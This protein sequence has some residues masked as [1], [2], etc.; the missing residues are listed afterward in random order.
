MRMVMMSKRKLILEDG[1]TFIGK[2]FGSDQVTEG[3]VIFN[4]GMTGY[5]EMMSDP[6][7]CG[8]IAVMTY[9]SIGSYGINRDDFESITPFINGLVTKEVNHEPSNFRSEE[10][11]DAFMK[12]YNIPGISGIDTRMLTRILRDKGTMRGM[13]TDADT[14]FESVET[15]LKN[16]EEALL[17]EK[18]SITRPYI[19]PGDGA[20]VVV[21]DLGMKQ[22]IL[23]ELTNL[24]C[25]VTVVPYDYDVDEILRFKPDGILVANGPGNP[26]Y[27]HKTVQTVQALL[28]KTPIFGIGLGHQILAQACGAKIA[29][30]KAGN[31]GPGFPVKDLATD[32]TWLTTQSRHYYVDEAS[33]EGTNLHVTF[34]SLN[35]KTIEGLA[36]DTYPAFSVQFNPEGAPGANDTVYLFNQFIDLMT[37]N[38]E[39]NGGQR[40]A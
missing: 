19:V 33:L 8:H 12:R 15:V 28:G 35:D 30:L 17:V 2:A 29:K 14:T 11:L 34:R 4:T 39:K 27:V 7:Y 9:P 20:R 5:Q 38:T 23:H 37:E 21:V 22:T 10:T 13:I 6:N 31:Y 18:T 1:T 36:H 3:E 26:T 24:N 40:H 32:Q 25:H 16:K